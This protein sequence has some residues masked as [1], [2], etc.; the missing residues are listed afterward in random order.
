MCL[1]VNIKNVS[2]VIG[3]GDFTLNLTMIIIIMQ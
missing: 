1:L 2:F 3:R